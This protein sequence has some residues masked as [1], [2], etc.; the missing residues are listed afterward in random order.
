MIEYG[1]YFH[2]EDIQYHPLD[3]GNY[4]ALA[5]QRARNTDNSKKRIICVRNWANRYPL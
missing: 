1:N 4:L 2:K 3:G 5:V